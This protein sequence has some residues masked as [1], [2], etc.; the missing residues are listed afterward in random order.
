MTNDEIFF[1]EV[2]FVCIDKNLISKEYINLLRGIIMNTRSEVYLDWLISRWT[3]IRQN[4]NHFPKLFQEKNKST[5]ID[6]EGI[7]I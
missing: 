6:G 2:I 3:K 5:Y 4:K 7:Q 1:T